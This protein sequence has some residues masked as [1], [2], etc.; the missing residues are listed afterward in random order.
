MTASAPASS[1]PLASRTQSPRTAVKC[2][3]AAMT[4]SRSDSHSSR[5]LPGQAPVAEQTLEE[6]VDL[7]DVGRRVETLRRAGGPDARVC[8]LGVH[9]L[10]AD[11]P[12]DV[13]AQLGR[14]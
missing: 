5:A 3:I 14:P 13:L 11:E 9:G 7:A 1:R 4:A 2:S 6:A 10:L 8:A 12:H